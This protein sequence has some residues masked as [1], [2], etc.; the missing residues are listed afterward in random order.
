M[1]MATRQIPFDLGHTPSHA[2]A[3][4]LVADGNAMAHANLLSWPRWP[5]PLTLLIGPAHA[6]KSHLSR[7]WAER[8]GAVMATPQSLEYF[9]RAGGIDPVVVEDVD[10]AGYEEAAL[11]HLFNQ[12]MRDRR[13][14]LM[15][16]R[17]RVQ[18]W[19]FS[20]ADLTSRA[21]LAATFDVAPVADIELSQ[22]LVKLLTDR[23]LVV[24][25]KVISYLLARME[26]SAEEVARIVDA[27]D[28]LS[29]ARGSGISR[30]I[31]AEALAQ[32]PGDDQGSGAGGARDSC[33][34]EG[35]D[36]E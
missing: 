8:A 25:P 23:Q 31:A 5:G 9:S 14:L 24:E 1:R 13:P 33:G 17:L 34:E 19:P 16:A 10:R 22:M 18:D 21:R 2:A 36:D 20:T 15:T 28:A 6:G 3:D 27:M 30:K 7:I 32:R 11:F 12:S 29:L 26:R 4:F 35:D